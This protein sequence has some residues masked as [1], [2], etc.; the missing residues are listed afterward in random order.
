MHV[1]LAVVA[2]LALCLLALTSLAGQAPVG[3]QTVPPPTPRPSPLPHIYC[4][5]DV[6][7]GYCVY[8]PLIEAP[9]CLMPTR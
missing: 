7:P 1:R 3:A 5:I 6:Y 4:A 2:F 9:R 8:L